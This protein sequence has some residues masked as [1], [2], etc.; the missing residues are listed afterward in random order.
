MTDCANRDLQQT[1]TNRRLLPSDVTSAAQSR[2]MCIA[3]C[4][5]WEFPRREDRLHGDTCTCV[6]A[7]LLTH[8]SPVQAG[9]SCLCPCQPGRPAVDVGSAAGTDHQLGSRGPQLPQAACGGTGQP[10]PTACCPPGPH[11][12]LQYF[13]WHLLVLEDFRSFLAALK[14]RLHFTSKSLRCWGCRKLLSYP[15]VSSR[16][17]TLCPP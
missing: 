6:N 3:V 1:R 17:L 9:S 15:S 14:Q 5:S 12:A 11:S 4:Y 2:Q 10:V 13:H 8:N 7:L 16:T